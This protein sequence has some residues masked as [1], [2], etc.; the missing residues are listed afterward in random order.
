[1]DNVEELCDHLCLLKRG[2]SL[3]TGS[4]LDLKKQ[5]GKTKLTIRTEYTKRSIR[6]F[7]G[8]KEIH[9]GKDQ[10]MLTLIR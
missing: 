10:Y 4:L 1:M 6:K 5:Y 8:V 2:V 3:F 7:E 9:V